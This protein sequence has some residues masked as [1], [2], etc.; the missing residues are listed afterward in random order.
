MNNTAT[1]ENGGKITIEPNPVNLCYYMFY[2][3]MRAIYCWYLIYQM[4]AVIDQQ[5]HLQS[6]AAHQREVYRHIDE[7]LFYIGLDTID[8]NAMHRYFYAGSPNAV[9]IYSEY[10]GVKTLRIEPDLGDLILRRHVF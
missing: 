3:H 7:S 2:T 8:L 10:C 9:P 1:W 5:D 6:I 4:P